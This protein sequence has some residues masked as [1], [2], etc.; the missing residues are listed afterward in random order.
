MIR[1]TQGLRHRGS[2]PSYQHGLALLNTLDQVTDR[3]GRGC[4]IIIG[5]LRCTGIC[6]VGAETIHE[7]G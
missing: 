3:V 4:G 2:V 6:H 1:P 7:L 5:P